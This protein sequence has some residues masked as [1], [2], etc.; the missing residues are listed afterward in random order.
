[1]ADT[2]IQQNQ[3]PDPAEPILR[4]AQGVDDG[5]RADAWDA[6]H[7]SQNEDELTQR[8][9]NVN[10]PSSVKAD[11][12]D[13]KH[14]LGS[15][16]TNQSAGQTQAQP[17]GM[18]GRFGA[19]SQLGEGVIKGA[20]ETVQ[21][22]VG[23]ADTAANWIN[24][25]LGTSELHAPV[26]FEGQ[27]LEGKTPLESLGKGAEGLTEFLLGDEALKGLSLVE[28]A[29]H[30]GDAGK[31]LEKSP[32]LAK[33][34]EIGVNALR[35]GTV[36][37]TQTLAHGGT[38][39]DALTT[40]VVTGGT[41]AVLEGLG[42]GVKAVKS[43]ITRGAQA[44]ELGQNL[45]KGLTEG[46][47]PEQVAKTVATNLDAVEQKMYADYDKGWQTISEQGKNVPVKISGSPVQQT[48]K[49]LLSDSNIPEAVATTLK[50]VV[51]DSEKLEPFL[52]LLANA[53]E[54]EGGNVKELTLTWDQT[55]ATRQKIGETIRKLPYDSPIRP[56]LIKLRSAIDDTLEKAAGDANNP[57]LSD[58][59]KSLRGKYA[60]AKNALDERAILALRD[61]NPNAVA[62]VL[63][64]KTSVHNVNTLRRLIG[65]QNMKAVEGSIL[66][67][68]IQDSSKN[69]ELQGRQL[70][71]KFN[72]LGPD[73]K[74]A[75]WGDRL[76]QVEQF[77]QLTGKLP[78]VVLDKI[79][80][81][82]AP[83]AGVGAGATLGAVRGYERDGIEGAAKGAVVGGA[84]GATIV[85]LK[86][87]ITNPAV[88]EYA[89]KGVGLA[90]KSIP[91][92][93]GA[94][95]STNTDKANKPD[96]SGVPIAKAGHL[97]FRDSQGGLHQIPE[98]HLDAAR[99]VDP[100]LEVVTPD[101]EVV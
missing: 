19:Y 71:R 52:T 46:A 25:K 79:V 72:S 26:P 100:K 84:T 51:P 24:R 43:F 12:W 50:G 35:Q 5:S 61:K 94:A 9:Q 37:G 78:N 33:A 22:V 91:P 85:G 77:M 74:Q 81:H 53:S 95:L 66:D 93:A 2:P 60:E 48:A 3:T 68:M 64:N 65:P 6:F 28:K 36:G 7:G 82:F 62:D 98:E 31:L 87:I 49:A 15:S 88:L 41:G 1:M 76:P 39:G 59:I 13:A 73:A 20:K 63:L 30:L 16:Q 47:T 4:S 42:Q 86:A 90:Q 96:T 18:A 97:I 27:D 44:E 75:I 55:E 38:I 8:L 17:E 29:K 23:A 58:H 54:T 80:G 14:K 10:I 34:V 70:Y 83:Y 69:G 11:L 99:E 89:L 57:D 101:A 92:V 45:A 32:K 67:K 40:G 56:D 21:G